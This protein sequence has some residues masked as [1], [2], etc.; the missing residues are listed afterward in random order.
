MINFS[1]K[2]N[3][4]YAS[5]ELKINTT[6][7]AWDFLIRF[8]ITNKLA[9]IILDLSDIEEID[10]A[11]VIFLDEIKTS[12]STPQ[13]KIFINNIP[14][15]IQKAIDTFST[16]QLPGETVPEK[17]GFVELIGEK[18]LKNVNFRSG[19]S[20]CRKSSPGTKR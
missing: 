18:A 16:S 6:K 19:N 12:Y 2:D 1:V 17:V 8:V 11:G 4:I 10:S 13:I 14:P 3:I 9:Q 7:T 20:N 5:G 15:N